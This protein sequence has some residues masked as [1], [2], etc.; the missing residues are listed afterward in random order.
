MEFDLFNSDNTNRSMKLFVFN[1]FLHF[2][3]GCSVR[4]FCLPQNA[5]YFDSR[6]RGMLT[7]ILI[8]FYLLFITM[9]LYLKS[10]K[11]RT[12]FLIQHIIFFVCVIVSFN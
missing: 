2:L 7:E 4:S 6:P 8:R 1:N 3:H 9:L 12:K 11:I 10:E 5:V